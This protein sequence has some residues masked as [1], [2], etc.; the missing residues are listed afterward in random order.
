MN[1]IKILFVVTEDWYFCSHRL[2]LAIEAKERGFSVAIATTVSSHQLEIE[3][4][5]IQVIPLKCMRRSSMSIFR[6]LSAI[7]ELILIYR[8]FRPTL[9]HHVALKPVIYGSLAARLLGVRARVSAL[10]GLGFIF[11]SD[12]FLP[13]ILRPPLMLIFRLIF[14]D[15]RSILILQNE[16]DL[17]LISNEARVNKKFLSLIRGAGVDMRKYKAQSIADEIPI[18]M[19]ASRMLWDKGVGEFVKA[20]EILRCRGISCRFVLTGKPDP[21]NPNSVP[22]QQ[23]QAWTE[24][25][26]IEWW[27]YSEDMPS[28]L[29]QASI[30]CLPSYYGEGIPKVLIEA[31]ACARAIITTNM[32]GCSELVRSSQNGL[33]VNPRDPVGLANAILQILSSKSLCQK[34]GNEGRKIAESDYSLERVVMETFNLYEYLLSK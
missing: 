28:T 32:P 12:N 29:S 16:N 11:T 17:S 9:V 15:E 22:I 25:N 3:R 2:P 31:M 27:G 20:A 7:M 33:L 10:G 19:L 1:R 30:V 14:N 13:L 21:E 23:M 24:S 5:G 6:E 18:V 8:K 34:M 4:H 26:V